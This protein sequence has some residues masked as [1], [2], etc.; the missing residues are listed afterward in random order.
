[1]S[2]DALVAYAICRQCA[3][4]FP[5]ER[6][7]PQCDQD[8]AAAAAIA[9]ATAHALEPAAQLRAN[10]ART[11]R[12]PHVLMS[13]VGVAALMLGLGVGVA[14]LVTHQATPGESATTTSATSSADR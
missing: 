13:L 2:S 7:C 6:R 11:Q 12:S 8:V 9:A 14:W 5:A 3:A 4:V 1:M 10:R